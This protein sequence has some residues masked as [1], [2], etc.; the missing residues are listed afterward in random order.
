MWFTL[1]IGATLFLERLNDLTQRLYSYTSLAHCRFMQ[2]LEAAHVL[3]R[4][5][6]VNLP[7]QVFEDTSPEHNCYTDEVEIEFEEEVGEQHFIQTTPRS[8]HGIL[9]KSFIVV[10]IRRKCLL[11]CL[12]VV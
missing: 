8:S 3:D 2:Y 1:I 4:C 11:R 10:N 7:L 12:E 6:L 5:F 9:Y